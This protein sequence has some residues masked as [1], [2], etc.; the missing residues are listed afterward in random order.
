MMSVCASKI[1]NSTYSVEV[2]TDK[3]YSASAEISRLPTLDL[4]EVS[5]CTEEFDPLK[6]EKCI[7]NSEEPLICVK[8]NFVVKEF[9]NGKKMCCCS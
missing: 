2:T 6:D 9:E 4:S 1:L 8:N 3:V 7:S 5:Q